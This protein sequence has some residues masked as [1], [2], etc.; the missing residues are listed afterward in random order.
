VTLGI[1]IGDLIQEP[2]SIGGAPCLPC[3]PAHC[4]CMLTVP[5]RTPTLALSMVWEQG[6]IQSR[7]LRRLDILYTPRQQN[8][9]AFRQHQIETRRSIGN[10]SPMCDRSSRGDRSSTFRWPQ[11]F[12]SFASCQPLQNPMTGAIQSSI[13]SHPDQVNTRANISTEEV[14]ETKTRHT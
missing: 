14:G 11:D 6:R 7:D 13:D 2:R 5:K 1:Q 9:I 8:R 3:R 12:A 10:R 4:L